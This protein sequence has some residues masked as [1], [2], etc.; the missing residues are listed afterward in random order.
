MEKYYTAG[1]ATDDTV[2]HANC[3]LYT[4]GYKHA[5]S[6]LIL[7]AFPMQQQLHKH[8]S[9]YITRAF[10]ILFNLI[11]GPHTRNAQLES[12]WLRMWRV[13]HMRDLRSH[14]GNDEYTFFAKATP[15][16]VLQIYQQTTRHH[17]PDD[18]ILLLLAHFAK[19]F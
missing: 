2:T 7:I 19:L 1:H 17:I 8:A 14:G 3:M 6:I 10:P 13:I 16:R 4:E 15:S 9:C 12:I 5:L 11:W 18:S